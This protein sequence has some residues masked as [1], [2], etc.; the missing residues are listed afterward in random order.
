[1][2]EASQTADDARAKLQEAGLRAAVI[3][4]SDKQ[5]RRIL[6]AIAAIYLMA[7]AAVALFPSGGSPLGLVAFIVIVFGGLAGSL[8]LLWRIRAYSRTGVWKFTVSAA[9]FTWWN[10]AVAGVSIATGWWA[11]HQPA[12]HF[13]VSAV[14]AVIPLLVAAWLIGRRA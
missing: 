14:V 3:R 9:A 2:L 11:P 8:L 7:A 10:A 6:L 1:M 4:R 5:F 13:S 12:T